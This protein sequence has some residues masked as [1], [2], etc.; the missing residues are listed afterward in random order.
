MIEHSKYRTGIGRIS[1][2]FPSCCH[3]KKYYLVIPCINQC[4]KVVKFFL[5]G[6][7]HRQGR[8]DNSIRSFFLPLDN[9]FTIITSLVNNYDW[10][11]CHQLISTLLSAKTRF[12]WV[13]EYPV[14]CAGWLGFHGQ[15][16][17]LA[18]E[19]QCFKQSLCN[20]ARRYLYIWRWLIWNKPS[21]QS[22]SNSSAPAVFT[23]SFR[24]KEAYAWRL[25]DYLIT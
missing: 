4:V 9:P 11:R 17:R 2:I 14:Q 6:G 7:Q 20:P 23:L 15:R 10:I 25:W 13:N 16:L 22:K 3:L 12:A 8:G 19:C 5:T 24:I 1:G 21:V 18:L